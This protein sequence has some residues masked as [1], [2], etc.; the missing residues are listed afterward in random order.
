MERLEFSNNFASRECDDLMQSCGNVLFYIGEWIFAK[1]SK[2][3][4]EVV[5]EAIG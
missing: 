2:A 3:S 4:K 1:S 5:V